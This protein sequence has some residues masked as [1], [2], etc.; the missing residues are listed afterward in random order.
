[1]EQILL[2]FNNNWNDFFSEFAHSQK[3]L[4]SLWFSSW[5]CANHFVVRTLH[6]S[7]NYS[8][9]RCTK[10]VCSWV[11]KSCFT[12]VLQWFFQSEVLLWISLCHFNGFFFLNDFLY[13]YLIFAVVQFMLFK[14]FKANQLNFS[15]NFKNGFSFKFF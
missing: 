3:P 14:R 5:C 11:V 12:T 1:M 2:N 9:F 6:S 13:F 8:S 4:H 15:S 7:L 10:F